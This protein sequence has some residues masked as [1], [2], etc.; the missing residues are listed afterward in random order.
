M[1]GTKMTPIIIE[2]SAVQMYMLLCIQMY[3]LL[4]IILFWNTDELQVLQ[5]CVA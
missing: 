4:C 3:M 2:D 5:S 1:T